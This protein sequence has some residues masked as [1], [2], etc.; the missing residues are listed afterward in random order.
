M[1][2]STDKELVGAVNST[3]VGPAG[4]SFF[5]AQYITT[6]LPSTQ[7]TLARDLFHFTPFDVFHPRTFHF[8]LP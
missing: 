8:R 7:I 2:G 3:T 4:L 1:F 6:D 5:H